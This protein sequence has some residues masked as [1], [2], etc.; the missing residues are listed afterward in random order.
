MPEL[1]P[2]RGMLCSQR[3]RSLIFVDVPDM[4]GS[5]SITYPELF[6]P[7]QMMDS[8]FESFCCCF[9]GSP[10][11]SSQTGW[12]YPNKHQQDLVSRLDN[13]LTF[14]INV[15]IAYLHVR[16]LGMR[17]WKTLDAGRAAMEDDEKLKKLPLALLTSALQNSHHDVAILL[18][19][20]WFTPQ[21]NF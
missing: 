5:A 18:D 15:C 13:P 3:R 9:Q 10:G 14:H 17:L 20:N 19:H 6:H 2:Y 8:S 1:M 16:G 4:W 12:P 7:R 21:C 11:S